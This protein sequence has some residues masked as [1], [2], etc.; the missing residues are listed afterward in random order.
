MDDF[1]CCRKLSEVTGTR[2][3][4]QIKRLPVL[5]I[6]HTAVCERDKMPQALLDALKAR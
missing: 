4:D 2:E 5:P 6:R 1:A 3:P